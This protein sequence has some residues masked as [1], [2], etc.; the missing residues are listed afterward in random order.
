MSGF[1]DREITDLQYLEQ[2]SYGDKDFIKNMINTFIHETPAHFEQLQTYFNTASWSDF[3]ET[4]HKMKPTFQ[5]VGISSKM[6]EDLEYD[7]D[8]GDFQAIENKIEQL[9][10]IIDKASEELKVKLKSY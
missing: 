7:A 2:V 10:H 8:A 6:F 3:K 9:R 1:E 5:M 4:A